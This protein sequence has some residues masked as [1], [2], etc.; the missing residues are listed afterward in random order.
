MVPLRAVFNIEGE[1]IET[2]VAGTNVA[3]LGWVAHYRP[4]A[5]AVI[6]DGAAIFGTERSAI[7]RRRAKRLFRW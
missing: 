6:G 7:S 1:I 3:L 4:N 5:M 2:R